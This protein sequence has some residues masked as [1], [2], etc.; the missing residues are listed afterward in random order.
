MKGQG[1][2]IIEFIG[3]YGSGKSTLSKSAVATIE[4]AHYHRAGGCLLCP[5]S[6]RPRVMQA[7]FA[8]RWPRATSVLAVHYWNERDPAVRSLIGKILYRYAATYPDRR[9]DVAMMD[10][11]PLHVLFEAS[12]RSGLANPEA[13]SRVAAYLPLPD[14][15]VIADAPNRICLDRLQERPA[16]HMNSVMDPGV[17]LDRY[18]QAMDVVKRLPDVR[19]L[20]LQSDALKSRVQEVVRRLD[21]P[22][23]WPTASN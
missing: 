13:M 23:V 4:G 11:G 21:R 16:H 19:I 14:L 10:E 2:V 12:A 8:S 17:M 5:P 9:A 20:E 18:R 15:I 7:C 1:R 3:P 6:R 22:R